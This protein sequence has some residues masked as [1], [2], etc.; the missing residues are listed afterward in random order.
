MWWITS[1]W[2]CPKPDRGSCRTRTARAWPC[3]QLAP[4]LR[5]PESESKLF[6]AST[7]SGL[8]SLA[9]IG[10]IVEATDQSGNENHMSH[11][12]LWAA[13]II[14]TISGLAI[15]WMAAVTPALGQLDHF[16]FS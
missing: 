3:R 16:T 12:S 8:A 1:C 7:K 6:S 9:G 13:G 14:A 2:I 4:V 15:V 5:S 10:I 11:Q